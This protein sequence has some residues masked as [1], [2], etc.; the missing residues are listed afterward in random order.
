M[1]T[2]KESKV[3]GLYQRLLSEKA[4]EEREEEEKERA[5]PRVREHH[6]LETLVKRGPTNAGTGMML[7]SLKKRYPASHARV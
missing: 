2:R 1:L 7:A 5:F 3:T 4:L 6:L